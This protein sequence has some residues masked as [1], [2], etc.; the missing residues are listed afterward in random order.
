MVVVCGSVVCV[1]VCMSVMAGSLLTETLSLHC[2]V[3]I[4]S[5]FT[6]LNCCN[7]ANQSVFVIIKSCDHLMHYIMCIYLL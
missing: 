3:C 1:W 2:T 5:N 6:R 7:F 4:G